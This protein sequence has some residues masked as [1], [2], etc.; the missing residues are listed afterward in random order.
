MARKGLFSF[1]TKKKKKK[2]SKGLQIAQAKKKSEILV[3]ELPTPRPVGLTGNEVGNSMRGYITM[4]V[5]WTPKKNVGGQVHWLPRVVRTKAMGEVVPHAAMQ[6]GP[7]SP[8]P[9]GGFSALGEMA[10]LNLNVTSDIPVQIITRTT[11]PDFDRVNYAPGV[12]HYWWLDVA[13]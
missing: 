11:V 2:S 6:G 7:N 1:T 12:P 9:N 3:I 5:T 4:L 10:K 8:D 13:P